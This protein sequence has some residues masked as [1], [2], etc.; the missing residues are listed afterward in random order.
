MAVGLIAVSN[1]CRQREG[2]ENKIFTGRFTIRNSAPWF[3][4]ITP[5]DSMDIKLHVSARL[6]RTDNA[7]FTDPGDRIVGGQYCKVRLRGFQK[8]Q[9]GTA[10]LDHRA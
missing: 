4:G 2:N 1:P 8:D 5:G 7:K 3:T 9:V 6:A 10:D